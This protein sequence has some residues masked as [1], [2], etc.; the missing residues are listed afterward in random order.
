VYSNGDVSQI[1]SDNKPIDLP[2]LKTVVTDEKEWTIEVDYGKL[3]TNKKFRRAFK[4]EMGKPMLDYFAE[5]ERT[6]D[7]MIDGIEFIAWWIDGAKPE[8]R[9]WFAENFVTENAFPFFALIEKRFQV[10]S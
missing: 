1:E 2:T 3:R 7:E 6:L 10:K 4:D 9:E 5:N 8:M